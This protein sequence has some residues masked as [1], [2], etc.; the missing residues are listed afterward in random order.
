MRTLILGTFPPHES[1]RHFEFYYPNNQNRFWKVLAKLGSV[2]LTENH[3]LPAVEQRKMLMT[4][5]RVGVQ[6]IGKV[7]ETIPHFLEGA[8]LFW[9]NARQVLKAS[10]DAVWSAST[11]MPPGKWVRARR[12]TSLPSS[13]VAFCQ[14][15]SNM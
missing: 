14:R 10:A 7:D 11:K 4:Q 8:S 2:T 9:T 15:R 5:L 3:G 12:P 13:S 1:K 6:N